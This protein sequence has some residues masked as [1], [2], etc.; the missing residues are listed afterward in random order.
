METKGLGVGTGLV[1]ALVKRL[2][3]LWRQRPRCVT[4]STPMVALGIC[5][6]RTG[7]AWT[8]NESVRPVASVGV[9]VLVG[10]AGV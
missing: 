4:V 3:S 1:V 8:S 9:Y 10:A 7:R 6:E 5:V 2:E